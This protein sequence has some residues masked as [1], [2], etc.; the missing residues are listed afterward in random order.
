MEFQYNIYTRGE[1]RLKDQRAR[2][3][4]L[5]APRRRETLRKGVCNIIIIIIY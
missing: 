1:R 3:R 2:E 4:K 5:K